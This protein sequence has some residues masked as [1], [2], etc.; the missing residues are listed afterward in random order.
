M[1]PGGCSLSMKLVSAIA[2]V[3]LSESELPSSYTCFNERLD[4]QTLNCG[5]AVFC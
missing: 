3:S 2:L 5:S 1:I 4:P